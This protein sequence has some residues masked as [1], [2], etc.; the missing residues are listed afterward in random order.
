MHH[1]HWQRPTGSHFISMFSL[2][3]AQHFH[4]LIVTWIRSCVILCERRNI[5]SNNNT[6]LSAVLIEYHK[7]KQYR[8]K[9]EWA[10]DKGIIM[11]N[12]HF[13]RRCLLFFRLGKSTKSYSWQRNCYRQSNSRFGAR[14][15]AWQR[16]G[17]SRRRNE[18]RVQYTFR[19]RER[20]WFT[21]SLEKIDVT[22]KRYPSG[23]C[24]VHRICDAY[25]ISS[26]RNFLLKRFSYIVSSE[27]KLRPKHKITD[28]WNV[29]NSKSA[30]CS[31][32]SE[33]KNTKKR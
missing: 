12:H 11:F 22:W 27:S 17:N 29:A 9:C 21:D 25:Q 5:S 23:V 4:P 8:M 16:D 15:F 2:S 19:A 24:A 7:I 33:T 13:L 14:A 20:D 18:Q 26:K 1:P 10:H 28:R 6:Q 31:L 32:L 3:R 30:D